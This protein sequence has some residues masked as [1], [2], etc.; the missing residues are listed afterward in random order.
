[1]P[2]KLEFNCIKCDKKFSTSDYSY[3][4][5]SNGAIAARAK[6]PNCD[7][8]RMRFVARNIL[9]PAEIAKL[10]LHKSKTPKKSKSKSGGGRKSRGSKKSAG[11]RKRT[12]GRH[13]R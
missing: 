9:P 1:M 3:I 11:S 7:G 2:P 12:G 6:C 4:R 5:M 13:R 10:P 8:E